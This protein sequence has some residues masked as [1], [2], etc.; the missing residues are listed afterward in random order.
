MLSHHPTSSHLKFITFLVSLLSFESDIVIGP[1]LLGLLHLSLHDE[2]KSEIY[3]AG[4]LPPLLKLM[5]HNK[6]MTIL[7]QACRLCS[8]LAIN[9]MNKLNLANSGC[10][11]AILDL[12]A[13]AVRNVD[14][15]VK[16]SACG[17]IANIILQNDANRNL[18]IE[19][20]AI[21]PL[22]AILQFSSDEKTLLNALKALTNIAYTNGYTTSRILISGGDNVVFDIISGGDTLRL[23]EITRVSLSLLSNM[24]CSDLNQAHVG[25]CGGL[26]SAAV[27]ICEH[28]RYCRS[29]LSA[30]IHRLVDVYDMYVWRPLLPTVPFVWLFY[31]CSFNVTGIYHHQV[32]IQLRLYLYV[33]IRDPYVIAEA[34]NFL[35]ALVHDNSSNKV[36]IAYCIQIIKNRV[37]TF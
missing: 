6:S 33:F 18:T 12:A 34:A 1:A 13:S 27:R 35:L 11:H 20:D 25:A 22:I 30:L 37:E 10:F 26:V 29:T 28:G 14:N 31:W 8:S 15:I 5:V 19:L 4:A 32:G 2:M 3:L 16:S 7:A 21:R 17:A 9:P 23:L 24:C 36:K